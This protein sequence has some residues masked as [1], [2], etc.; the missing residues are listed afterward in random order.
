MKPGG[1]LVY[2]TCSLLREENEDVISDFLASHPDYVSVPVAEVL[3]RRHV[4]I[5]PDGEFLR[6][7]PHRHRTDGYFAAVMDRHS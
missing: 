6:L 4:E 5:T 3:A 7:L 1:R 2:A